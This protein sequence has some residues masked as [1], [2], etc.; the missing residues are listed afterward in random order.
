MNFGPLAEGE[1]GFRTARCLRSLDKPGYLLRRHEP[2]AIVGVPPEPAIGAAIA[3]KVCDR[4]EDVARV[5]N[6]TLKRLAVFLSL[7]KVQTSTQPI[8]VLVG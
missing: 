8:H 4:Q 1:Q 2:S 6:L 5:A 3:A 7:S